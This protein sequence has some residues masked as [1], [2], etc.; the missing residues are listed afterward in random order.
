MRALPVLWE[1]NRSVSFVVVGFI[2]FVSLFYAFIVTASLFSSDCPFQTPFSLLIHFAI[3][4]VATR[5]KEPQ[6]TLGPT[7]YPPQPEPQPE[8]SSP[9]HTT[10][11][12]HEQEA[13]IMIQF[14]TPLFIQRGDLEG[15][16][17]DARCIDLLFEMSTGSDV[18][19]SIMDFIPEITWHSGIKSV[20]VKRI[21]NILIG[22]FNFS[23]PHPVVIPKSRDLAYLSAKAFVHIALQRRCMTQREEHERDCWNILCAG[24]S[25]LSSGEYG[26]DSDLATVVF[27]VDTTLGCDN[28]LT[29]KG[30]SITSPHRAWMSHMFLYLTWCEGQV[31]Q[32]AM[33]FVVN[34]A[35]MRPPSGGA[36][37]ADCFFIIGLMIG[38]PLHV[39]DL[40]VGDK[41][42]DYF[43]QVP[44]PNFQSSSRE[45]NSALTKIFG[46]IAEIFSSQSSQVPLALCAL[47]LVTRFS[48]F[49]V[50]EGSYGLF[51]TIMVS[52][53]LTSKLWEAARYTAFATFGTGG[54]VAGMG[55][56]E[57]LRFLDY[58]LGL[59]GAGKYHE[60]DIN[61]V[62]KTLSR[63]IRNIDDL[64]PL[65]SR[66]LRDFNWTSPPFVRGVRSMMQPRTLIPFRKNT[67]S[68][69]ASISDKW[70]NCSMP[71]MEPEEMTEFCKHL[72]ICMEDAGH[73]TDV[74]SDGAMILFEMLRS[75]EWRKHIATEFW[76][77]LAYSTLVEELESVKRCLQNATKLW[78]FARGLDDGEG[79]K[80]W[81][82]T[83]W[84]HYDKLDT[85]VQEEVKKAAAGVLRSDRSSDLSL[86][87]SLIEG[88]ISRLQEDM[89]E[90]PVEERREDYGTKLRARL[91]TMEGNH[92]QLARIVGDPQ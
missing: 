36:V 41:R 47:R 33:D 28:R 87:L 60:S 17:L 82:G 78:E 14:P 29:W 44:F 64:D 68:L 62:L 21:Y 3:A 27:M 2:C 69:V 10:S 42:L 25:P 84:L 23:G 70:F 9:T 65:E 37:V 81:Y 83:L 46:T 86:Y 55:P 75:S 88:E 4:L 38:I 16:R 20:P 58:H 6:E 77:V 71:I 34:S 31:S 15:D 49:D 43:P 91:I 52:D 79:L 30:S 57:I 40:T 67:V 89:N 85:E 7:Q 59:Q 12:E 73:G 1:V 24:H 80:W 72:A 45:R 66:C 90:L 19:I 51:K 56:R 63:R 54:L 22:C 11:Q 50:V 74:E 76:S 5:R 48:G 35:S 18:A 8:P 32:A 13:K 39:S 92:R 53:T 61:C 26:C